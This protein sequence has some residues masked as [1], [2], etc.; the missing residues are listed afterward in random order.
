MAETSKKK[1]S[2]KRR[3]AFPVGLLVVALTIIGLIT[4]IIGLVNGISTAIDKSKGYEEYEKMLTPVV[5]IDPDTFDDITNADMSQLI[6]MSIWS[7]LKNDN[8]PDRFETNS[9]GFAIPKAEVEKAFVELFG[10]EITPV[11]S[12]VEGYGIEFSYDNA[13]QTYTVPLTGVTPIYT[14][15]VIDIQKSND[16]IIL[17]VGCVAGDAWEQG[18]NGEMIAPSPDKYLKVTLREVDGKR[19]ISAIQSTSAPEEAT[20][21]YTGE[22][23]IEDPNVLDDIVATEKPTESE[24]EAESETETESETTQQ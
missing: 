16:T 20:T 7:L 18:E 17:T 8:S 10:T 9:M 2:I 21:E 14:P 11:H 4:V 13:T 15:D 22:K 24:S 23:P 3:L 12:T 19:F 6:E 5:L 1:R